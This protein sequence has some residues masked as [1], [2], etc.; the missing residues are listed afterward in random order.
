MT[1]LPHKAPYLFN[2][3]VHEG[4]KGT[5][6]YTRGLWMVSEDELSPESQSF[7]AKDLMSKRHSLN[8]LH[9]CPVHCAIIVHT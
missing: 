4:W 1:I 2:K 8:V 6:I 7:P 3:S 9:R 5:K